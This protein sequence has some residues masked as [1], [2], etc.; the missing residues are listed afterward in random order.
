MIETV[1]TKVNYDDNLFFIHSLVKGLRGG[2]QLELDTGYFRDKVVE[3]VFFIDRT[4][5]QVYEILKSN[6]YLINRRDHLR[7]LMR[8]KRAFAD[9]L[10]SIVDGT[11]PWAENLSQFTGK[12]A[13]ARDSHVG[14]IADIQGIMEGAAPV[15]D[16]QDVVSQNEYR[17]LFDSIDE[18]D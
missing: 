9:L 1:A 2:L 11:L 3:D 14:D 4:L 7:E 16:P 10:T 6:S 5:Q 17:F 18:D 15:D 13:G 12:L 8:V